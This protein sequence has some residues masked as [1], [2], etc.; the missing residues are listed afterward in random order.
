MRGSPVSNLRSGSPE[1]ATRLR[2]DVTVTAP[3]DGA[4]GALPFANSCY[5]SLHDCFDSIAGS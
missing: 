3:P 5:Y 4:L 2:A 1:Y